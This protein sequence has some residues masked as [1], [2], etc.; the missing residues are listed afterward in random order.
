MFAVRYDQETKEDNARLHVDD[1]EEDVLSMEYEDTVINTATF[2]P[3]TN[4]N[5]KNYIAWPMDYGVRQ[6]KGITGSIARVI[7]TQQIK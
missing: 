7:N 5:P 2:T 1:V 4:K 6:V 3:Y